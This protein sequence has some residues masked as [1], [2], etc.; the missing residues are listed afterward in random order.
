MVEEKVDTA[1]ILRKTFENLSEY[2]FEARP[3][4][5]NKERQKVYLKKPQVYADFEVMPDGMKRDTYKK[6]IRDTS[7]R[8]YVDA[9]NARDMDNASN[10][11]WMERCLTLIDELAKETEKD[12]TPQINQIIGVQRTYIARKKYYWEA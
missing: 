4:F 3:F 8:N 6:L 2:E 5:I 12:Y 9:L 1:T 7:F 11:K 10:E